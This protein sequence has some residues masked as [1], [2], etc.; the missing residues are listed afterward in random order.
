M[1]K[2]LCYYKDRY[3]EKRD[4]EIQHIENVSIANITF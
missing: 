1:E 4:N 3:L 2:I